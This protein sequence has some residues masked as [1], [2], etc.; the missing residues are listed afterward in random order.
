MTKQLISKHQ[1]ATPLIYSPNKKNTMQLLQEALYKAGFYKGQINK[2]T[3]KQITLKE[4]ADGVRGNQTNAAITAAQKAGYTIDEKSGRI[5][6]NKSTNKTSVSYGPATSAYLGQYTG[7]TTPKTVSTEETKPAKN[8]ELPKL[9]TE[10]AQKLYQNGAGFTESALGMLYHIMAPS[11]AHM[12]YPG[13]IKDQIA[14]EIAYAESLPA[15]HRLKTK[16]GELTKLDYPMHGV[17]SEQDEN[18]NKQ[19]TMN[20]AT[21]KVMGGYRYVVNPDNSVTISDNYGFGVVRDYDDDGNVKAVLNSNN[22]DQDPYANRQWA[23]L[24]H[25]I[26]ANGWSSLSPSVLQNIAENFG[27][28]Q[29]VF[30]DNSF[31]FQ[32][33]EIAQRVNRQRQ[34]VARGEEVKEAGYDPYVLSNVAFK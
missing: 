34:R 25:D 4:A 6:K 13:D 7:I 33:G 2:K 18:V 3:G 12:I 19:G 8:T 9:T 10:E 31:T 32:P 11:S 14:T 17:L 22:L 23:G 5:S 24:M 1:N 30:R 27:T 16:E 28:R 15:N 29:G 26:W 21:S 20:N